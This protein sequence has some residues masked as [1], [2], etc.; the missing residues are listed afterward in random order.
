MGKTMNTFITLGLEELGLLRRVAGATLV[1]H[2]ITEAIEAIDNGQYGAAYMAAL[3]AAPAATV[4][5]GNGHSFKKAES[6]AFLNVVKLMGVTAE[7]EEAYQL[8]HAIDSSKLAL[9][10]GEFVNV[11]KPEMVQLFL[12]TLC[13]LNA[14]VEDDGTVTFGDIGGYVKPSSIKVDGDKVIVGGV[15]WKTSLVAA[16]NSAGRFHPMAQRIIGV[17]NPVR[18]LELMLLVLRQNADSYTG[19][20]LMGFVAAFNAAVSCPDEYEA[21]KRDVAG[22]LYRT[23]EMLGVLT[24]RFNLMNEVAYV[25][26]AWGMNL[27]KARQDLSAMDKDHLYVTTEQGL[28]LI[29]FTRKSL[30]TGNNGW[31]LKVVDGVVYASGK[32]KALRA[33]HS[34]FA[35]NTTVE[36]AFTTADPVSMAGTV[37]MSKMLQDTLTARRDLKLGGV[38]E[39]P[40]ISIMTE[41]GMKVAKETIRGHQLMMKRRLSVKVG[42]TIEGGDE[43]FAIG[44]V[45]KRLEDNCTMAQITKAEM[46]EPV[47]VAGDKVRIEF[48]IEAVAYD[49]GD[50]KLR[51][52]LKAMVNNYSATHVQAYVDGDRWYGMLAGDGVVKVTEAFKANFTFKRRGEVKVVTAYDPDS[53]DAV[54][55]LARPDWILDEHRHEVTTIDP[56]GVI[57][58]LNAKIES[59][60]I[61]ESVSRSSLGLTQI[62]ALSRFNAGNQLL[63]LLLFK[64]GFVDDRLGRLNYILVACDPKGYMK[65]NAPT[66]IIGKDTLPMTSKDTATDR[67]ILEDLA[68]AYKGG[69][70]LAVEMEDNTVQGQYIRPDHIAT[71]MST[72]DF[73]INAIGIYDAVMKLVR[74]ANDPAMARAVEWDYV[75][76][77]AAIRGGLSKHINTGDRKMSLARVYGVRCAVSSKSVESRAVYA[78]EYHVEPGSKIAKMLFQDLKAFNDHPEAHE[79]HTIDDIDGELVYMLRDPNAIGRVVTIRLNPNVGPNT[80]MINTRKTRGH[81]GGDWDGDGR[82]VVAMP[83][84]L[85]NQLHYELEAAVPDMDMVKLATGVSAANPIFKMFGEVLKDQTFDKMIDK[86]VQQPLD[87][88][89]AEMDGSADSARMMMPAAYKMMETTALLFGLGLADARAVALTFFIYE[90]RGLSG[91][92]LFAPEYAGVRNLIDL[93]RSNHWQTEKTDKSGNVVQQDWL[94][95][96]QNA[97]RVGLIEIQADYLKTLS[98]DERV[99]HIHK[100]FEEYETSMVGLI[101]SSQLNKMLNVE[102]FGGSPYEAYGDDFEYA[103]FSPIFNLLWSLGRRKMKLAGQSAEA[104]CAP[105]QA[106]NVTLK[107]I[108]VIGKFL[109]CED[110]VL[111][112][113]AKRA[114]LYLN[115][116]ITKVGYDPLIDGY[117]FGDD[118]DDNLVDFGG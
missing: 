100:L 42:D 83:F 47:A 36:V 29:R 37:L 38:F 79:I 8:L 99:A 89:L 23:T 75:G 49:I 45:V 95:A 4:L 2:D 21:S 74:A 3:S 86:S 6:E 31:G 104:L 22:M 64:S 20:R 58:V 90:H 66:F 35:G 77:F 113:I 103:D 73:G 5:V 102:T 28:D 80:S 109:K 91:V 13:D 59:S 48:V 85:G 94:P 55:A 46:L 19:Q 93:W 115:D 57:G 117:D 107:H 118:D 67:E 9:P 68:E 106:G 15:E 84:G 65:P 114:A 11:R 108:D 70:N 82:K 92:N 72:D 60:T 78:D 44:D 110:N 96:L 26:G 54:V 112:K 12:D 33:R 63:D 87:K 51:E 16:V 40:A 81:D 61:A 56:N 14:E 43:L 97:I 24:L 69:F 50:A 52:S 105:V 30:E 88:W 53:W 116:A 7:F 25:G 1:E 111:F 41:D 71:L 98:N 34:E 101:R 17:F 10:S 62:A 32:P 18:L 39:F 27:T 76:M